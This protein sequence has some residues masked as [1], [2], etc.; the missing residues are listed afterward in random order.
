VGLSAGG[1]RWWLLRKEKKKFG[2]GLYK[3]VSLVVSGMFSQRA[4][5]EE[6]RESTE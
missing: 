2:V 6:R 1:F 4:Q 5:R 3:K